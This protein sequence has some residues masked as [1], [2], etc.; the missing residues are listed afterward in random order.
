MPAETGH[1]EPVASGSHG[2]KAYR[3]DWTVL[4]LIHD[5][6]VA[7]YGG[8]GIERAAGRCESIFVAPTGYSAADRS[9]WC[10]RAPA[11]SAPAEP[12]LGDRHSWDFQSRNFLR[13]QQTGRLAMIDFE[14][15]EPSLTVRDLVR[16]EY[17]S[18]EARPDLRN[19][20]LEGY[21]R[22][23]RDEETEVLRRLGALDA[24]SGLRWGTAH[25]DDEVV[26]R[27]RTTSHACSGNRGAADGHD[28]SCPAED[29]GCRDLDSADWP[30]PPPR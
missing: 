16:L 12:D 8:R 2:A 28:I 11:S 7:V 3:T 1:A 14:R 23:H 10:G 6:P 21:G 19:A 26:H 29:T 15:A 30:T 17:G 24:L 5:V 27:T 18:W 22:N 20:F 13:D 9:H 4:R 25:G